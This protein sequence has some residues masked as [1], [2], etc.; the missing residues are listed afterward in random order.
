MSFI[1]LVQRPL[2]LLKAWALLRCSEGFF[3][4]F[5]SFLKPNSGALMEL[6]SMS[7]RQLFILRSNF[8][9]KR[10]VSTFIID[11][12]IGASLKDL[13][14]NKSNELAC[15]LEKKT[16]QNMHLAAYL[17]WNLKFWK[18]LESQGRGDLISLPA[19]PLSDR[20]PALVASQK[21]VRH[22]T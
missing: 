10:P 1:K 20:R 19:R 2:T 11:R 17:S 15:Q 5:S 8:P 21:L 18:I 4:P 22:V 14:I 13:A 6:R 3:P 9:L 7:S 12:N 16:P